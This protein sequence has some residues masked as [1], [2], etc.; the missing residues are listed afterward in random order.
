[1]QYIVVDLDG[2][3]CDCSHRVTLA[4]A[5]QWDEFHALCKD[6]VPFHKIA[7]MLLALSAHYKMLVVSG[8]S[9]TQLK[10]TLDWMVIW[11][12]FTPEEVLLR[13]KDDYRSDIELKTGLLEEFFGSKEAVLA[14]VAFCLDDRDKVVE[15]LR[16]YGLTVLQVREGDY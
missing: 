8:R 15:G 2:T 14:S 13:P 16:N 12:C 9:A 1:M 5:G 7:D 6:D 10:A 11:A 4:Q 3:L